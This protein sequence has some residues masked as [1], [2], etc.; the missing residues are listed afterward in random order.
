MTSA[1][2]FALSALVTLGL[3]AWLLS[4]I[5]RGALVDLVRRVD[6][7]LFAVFVA[8]S[9]AGLFVRA[10]RYSMLLRGRAGFWPVVGVTAARN[11]LVDLLPA[12]IGSLSYVYLLTARV[13]VPLEPVLSSF[14][15]SFV[16]DLL[17]MA[18][19]VG[20]ALSLELG[21][22]QG[23]GTLAVL[24]AIFAAAS[25]AVFVSLA[26]A[27]RFA[28]R[29]VERIP[30]LA[31]IRPRLEATA[32]EIE[33]TGRGARALGLVAISFVI[34]ILKFGAYWALLLAV[35]HERG[36]GT[37]ELPF[38]RVFLGIAAAELSATLPIHGIAGF[39]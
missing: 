19:L 25:V 37:T 24:L 30:R 33:A 38:W 21:S 26:P 5:D 20:L 32:T 10:L 36:F 1:L 13:G 4:G 8:L 28:A 9:F 7:P 3:S 23:A 27:V 16:Y 34:R 29:V 15:L 17:A 14:V 2:R 6:R 31:G 39:G 12:R 11:F 35:L 18:L 22:F